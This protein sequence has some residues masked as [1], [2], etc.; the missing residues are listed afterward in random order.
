MEVNGSISEHILTMSGYSNR[1]AE[2][3]MPL[4]AEAITNRVLQSLP[5]SYKSFVMN[6]NMHEM[7]KSVAELFAMLKVVE[8]EIQKE[9]QVLMVNKTTS[10]KKNGKGKGKKGKTKKDGKAVAT[11]TKKPKHGPKP[12][13]ECFHCK[14][15]GHWKQNCPKYLADKKAANDKQGIYDI[16][17][18]DVYLTN[19]N[20]SACV[21][22]TV[23]LLTF[24]T[25]TMS[26]GIDEVWLRT[27]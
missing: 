10:F 4:S 19:S 1:L 3:G 12:E 7:N 13:T 16:H 26:Y 9:H 15:T 8:S 22:Y 11:P 5:P 18:I 6:Y 21:F 17:V 14:G 25:K 24:A 2:L 20:S 23:W 27:K